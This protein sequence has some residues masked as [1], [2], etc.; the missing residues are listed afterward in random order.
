MCRM[1]LFSTWT[2][3]H[4]IAFAAPDTVVLVGTV[5]DLLFWAIIACS[6]VFNISYSNF[7]SILHFLE[8]SLFGIHRGQTLVSVT[9]VI[10]SL[11]LV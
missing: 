6:N 2:P 5:T 1:V 9:S 8:L 4:Q 3:I 10:S 7:T 11:M